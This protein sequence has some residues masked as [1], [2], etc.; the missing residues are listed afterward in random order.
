MA[1]TDTL[2]TINTLADLL[3]VSDPNGT[4]EVSTSTSLGEAYE[5]Q[6]S[7]IEPG[8]AAEWV[9]TLDFKPEQYKFGQTFK[10]AT[11]QPFTAFVGPNGSVLVV[12]LT[13]KA[14]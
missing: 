12:N 9:A 6:A 7:R 5:S 11:G 13:P 1:K 4:V 14:E 3:A 10:G 2:P 8:T